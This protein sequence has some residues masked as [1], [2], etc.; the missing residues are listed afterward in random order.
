[1]SGKTQSMTARTMP[2]T[3][4]AH[5]WLDVRSKD[6]RRVRDARRRAEDPERRLPR[7]AR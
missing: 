2:M 1:M 6:D 4:G 7:L 5:H 3:A